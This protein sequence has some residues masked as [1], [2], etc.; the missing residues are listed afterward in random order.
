MDQFI[1]G[2]ITH[3][4]FNFASAGIG[5]LMG[6]YLNR[7]RGIEAIRITEFNKAAAE[8]RSRFVDI[9]WKLRENTEKGEPSSLVITREDRIVLEKAKILFEPFLNTAKLDGLNKAWLNYENCEPDYYKECYKNSVQMNSSSRQ[10]L[11]RRYIDRFTNILEFAKPK[12]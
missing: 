1:M 11:S 2:I 9:I 7:S 12:L 4:F 6:H 5:F 3:P 10:E 8:F